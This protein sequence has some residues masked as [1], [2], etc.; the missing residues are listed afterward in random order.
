MKP[1]DIAYTVAHREMSFKRFQ[2]MCDL[3]KKHGVDHGERYQSDMA[4]REFI[5]AIDH[6]TY[7]SRVDREGDATSVLLFDC[8]RRFTRQNV[9]RERS[10][11][12]EV[13][14]RGSG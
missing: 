9:D 7:V 3:E 5:G 11:Q 1:F 10:D 6:V 12:C 8:I 2:I 14:G 13:S 4:C